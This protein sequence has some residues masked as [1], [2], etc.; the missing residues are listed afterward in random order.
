MAVNHRAGATLTAEQLIHRHLRELALDVPQRDIDRRD[1]GHRDGPAPPV[2]TAIEVLPDVLDV[3]RVAADKA[4]DDVLVEIRLHGKLAAIER[5]VAE[6]VH[7]FVGDDLQRHEIAPGTR[8]DRVGSF[9]L[10]GW[11]RLAFNRRSTW[12]ARDR[13]VPAGVR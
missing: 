2:G 10:H 13:A 5:R 12:T 7:A 1:G 4:R 6:T 9:D 3:V 11:I 8:E